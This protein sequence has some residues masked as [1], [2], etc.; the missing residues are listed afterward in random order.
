MVRLNF[1][2]THVRLHTYRVQVQKLVYAYSTASNFGMH[3]QAS[4]HTWYMR[5]ARH[6]LALG[7][8]TTL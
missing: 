5:D 8:P 6:K 3:M 2:F 4:E 7:L 1:N